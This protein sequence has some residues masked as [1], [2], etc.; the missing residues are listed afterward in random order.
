MLRIDRICVYIIM[1]GLILIVPSIQYISYLDEFGALMFG[2]VAAL[3]CIVNRNW[4]KYKL[5]WIVMAIMAFY[6]I[7]SVTMV[8]FNVAKAV[9]LDWV[10]TIKPFLPFIVMFAVAPK[11]TDADKKIIRGICVFNA[12]ILSFAFCCGHS[13]VEAIVFHVTYGGTAIFASMMFYLYCSIDSNGKISRRSIVAAI[14][15]LTFG[16]L[17][18][19][20]KY[21]GSYVLVLYFI[22][23]YRPGMLRQLTPFKILGLLLIGALVLAVSWHKI[24]YYFLVGNGDSFDPTVV[25]SFARPVLYVTGFLIL[26]DFFPFGTGLGSFA[27]FASEQFYS[28]VYYYYGIDKVYGLSPSYS[29]FICDA[30][31]P[32]LAQFGIVGFIL[33]ICFWCYTYNFLRKAIRISG[34]SFRY[35]FIIGALLVCFILIEC[36]SGNTFTQIIGTFVMALYGIICAQGKE[37]VSKRQKI[38]KGDQENRLTRKI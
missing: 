30:Y 15:F 8:H 37:M 21:Y 14:I 12:A 23:A 6:A 32:S 17:C 24:E 5:L 27:S 4:G 34:E 31:Y 26:F 11:F 9:M 1:L 2:C 36:T 35:P 38:E 7:Y 19:R 3:D 10:I 28:G 22:F 33:F 13:V 16:L 29:S 25:Q 20:A 18:T